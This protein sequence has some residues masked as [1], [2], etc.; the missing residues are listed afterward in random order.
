MKRLLSFLLIACFLFCAVGCTAALPD[1]TS[2]TDEP[3]Y[4][5]NTDS[6]DEPS[7]IEEE[8]PNK[9]NIPPEIPRLQT[10]RLITNGCFTATKAMMIEVANGTPIEEAAAKAQ[11]AAES[12]LVSP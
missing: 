5:P 11:Q 1:D 6:P 7:T 8:I 9:P 10:L 4:A 2:G 12:A 3:I